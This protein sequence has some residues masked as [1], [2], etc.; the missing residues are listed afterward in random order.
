MHEVIDT[1]FSEIE[2]NSINV[3]KISDEQLEAIVNRI[4]DDLLK[5]SKYYIF[6]SNSKFRTLTKKL[7]RVI[8]ESMSYIVYTLRN[9]KFE[10]YGH[11]V[12]FGNDKKYSSI[13]IDLEDGRKVQI[14]GKIDRLD[15][16]KIDDKTYVR[17]I[18]YKSRIK[19]LDMNLFDSGLQIQL[20][21]YLDA[22]CK[23]DNFEPSGI[24]YSSLIDSKIKLDVGNRSLIEE[25]IKKALRKNFKMQGYV[26]ANI[27][28]IKMMDSNLSDG[29][30]S[31]I[32]PVSLK[33]DGEL[34]KSSKILSEEEFNEKQ[35][36]VQEIIK[37][38]SQ[39][40]YDGKIDIRPYSY[41]K[42]NGCKFCKY[43]SI[44]RFNP[45]QKDNNY[46]YIS[47]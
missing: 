47:G 28:V 7:K 31:D 11:E 29:V 10:L 6:S 26:L 25:Q 36:R 39:E 38:I 45:N 14:D 21:T 40:I 41:R 18:D 15:I 27:D 5:T 3:K 19:N 24:L 2:A 20:V 23:Q 16:G 46:N 22:V 8:L 32:I 37:E 33:K 42:N 12:E 35:N 30:S 43:L 44:C 13:M 34:S 17:I 1:F 9:S 4:I